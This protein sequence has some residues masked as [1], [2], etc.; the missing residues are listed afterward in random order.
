MRDRPRSSLYMAARATGMTYQEIADKYGVSRQA[1]A[2]ACAQRGMGRFR[3]YT[4][5]DVVYPNLRRWLNENQVS[6]GEFARRMDRVPVSET[7]QQVSEWFRGTVY[8]AK[9]SIDKM[10]AITG[11]TYEELFYEEGEDDAR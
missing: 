7:T 8:P 5:K 6:R 11:L 4:A 9:R 2:S 10:L 1:V 3:P